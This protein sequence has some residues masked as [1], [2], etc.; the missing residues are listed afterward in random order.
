MSRYSILS[1]D[2]DKVYSASGNSLWLGSLKAAK[3]ISLLRENNIKT[4][5]TVANNINPELKG[6][7]HYVN[8]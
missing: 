1:N 8:K 7:K 4:V 6:F 3:N 5:I 2:M